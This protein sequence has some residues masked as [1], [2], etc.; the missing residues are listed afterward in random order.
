MNPDLQLFLN[1]LK[2]GIWSLGVLAWMFGIT[3]RSIAAAGDG[4]LVAGD[5]IQVFTALL[6]F[7]GWLFLRPQK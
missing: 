6:L 7:V 4:A 5:L 2:T 1:Q 3:D